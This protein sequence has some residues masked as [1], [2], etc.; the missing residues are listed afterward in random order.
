MGRKKP[1]NMSGHDLA[2]FSL[3]I[4]CLKHSDRN[5]SD[6]NIEKIKKFSTI[7]DIMEAN[8]PRLPTEIC[9][10]CNRDLNDKEHGNSRSLKL[11]PN[12]NYERDVI[13]PRT[14]SESNSSCNCKLCQIYSKKKSLNYI[15]TVL[16]IQFDKCSLKQ[17][18]TGVANSFLSKYYLAEIGKGIIHVCNDTSFRQS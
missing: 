10:T 5:L 2:R 1:K 13:I 14:R 11:P 12:F 17:T 18:K 16:G 8:D 15:H 4:V 3:C 7:L 6:G 9:N